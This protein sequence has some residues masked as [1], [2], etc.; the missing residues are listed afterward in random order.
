M[1]ETQTQQ[2]TTPV[3]APVQQT[4]TESQT[5]SP[6]VT[7]SDVA[8]K[9]NVMEEVKNFTATPTPAHQPQQPQYQPQYQ[10]VP[11]PVLDAAGFNQYLNQQGQA[12]ANV[13]GQIAGSI[14]ELRREREQEALNVEIKQAVGRVNERLKIDPVYAELVLEKEY[15]SNPEFKRIWDNR[16]QYPQALV[17]ALDVIS[18]KASQVFQVKTDPQ[19][20]ENMRAAK[21]SQRAMATTSKPSQTEEIDKMNDVEFSQWWERKRLY[22]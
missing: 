16:K 9:Y 20:S 2:S 10:G 17:E 22:G 19:L 13:L 8:K 15:R 21:A 12:T 14:E 4:P 7:I 3:E 5:A 6:E 18:N 1:E 11:D